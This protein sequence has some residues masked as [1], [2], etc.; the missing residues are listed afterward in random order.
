MLTNDASAGRSRWAD[1]WQYAKG[2]AKR[3]GSVYLSFAL[4]AALFLVYNI[5]MDTQ[6]ME[7]LGLAWIHYA[8]MEDDE[9]RERKFPA[10]E[11]DSVPQR[12]RLAAAAASEGAVAVE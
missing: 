11:P 1:A 4:P 7:R 9:E 2:F 5:A 10:Y 12:K 8:R 3:V 6:D